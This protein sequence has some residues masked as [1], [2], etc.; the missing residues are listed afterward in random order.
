MSHNQVKPS[1]LLDALMSL[2]LSEEARNSNNNNNQA[3]HEEL[4]KAE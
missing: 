1:S 4:A 2:T 3:I